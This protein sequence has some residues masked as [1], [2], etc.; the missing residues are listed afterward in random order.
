MRIGLILEGLGLLY[1]CFCWIRDRPRTKDQFLTALTRKWI[2]KQEHHQKEVGLF[3]LLMLLGGA[4]SLGL[5]QQ[6]SAGKTESLSLERPAY[7]EKERQLDLKVTAENGKEKVSRNVILTI[8]PR[9]PDQATTERLLDQAEKE[10]REELA[11]FADTAGRWPED[12][13][14]VQVVCRIDAEYEKYIDLF[15]RI[16]W[17]EVQED[18]TI[19]VGVFLSAYGRTRTFESRICLKKQTRTLSQTLSDTLNNLEEGRYLKEDRMA[20][21]VTADNGVHLSY[22]KEKDRESPLLRALLLILVL[23]AIAAVCAEQKYKQEKKQRRRRIY[24]IY[25]EMLNKMTI[26]LGAGMSI[27]KAWERITADY[28]LEKQRTSRTEPLYE[29]MLA[30][31]GRMHSGHS[32]AEALQSFAEKLE[33]KEIRQFA[34]ILT[35]GWRSGDTHLLVHL[36]ELNDRSW[37]IRKKQIRKLSEEADTRLLLPLMMMLVVVMIIVLSPAMM[38][39]RL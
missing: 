19:P 5:A 6:R 29:E 27:V 26:L 38:T 21:P 20:L 35:A 36:K 24:H 17:E 9:E 16:Q 4:V 8:P 14:E 11:S 10:V 34:A 31:E 18:I 13:E 25:P 2:R 28:R 23:P 30:A 12:R 37:E 15:G 39:M 22:E 32:V 1:C 3:L 7:G 33:I